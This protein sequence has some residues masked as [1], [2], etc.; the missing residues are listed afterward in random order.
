MKRLSFIAPA[1]L[2]GLSSASIAAA[3]PVGA[4]EEPRPSGSESAEAEGSGSA[5]IGAEIG[6]EGDP[7]AA[8]GGDSRTDDPGATGK[9][10]PKN[11]RKDQKWIHRW[12]PEPMTGELGI[13]G[14]VFL[15]NSRLELFEPDLSLPLQG[16][17]EFNS[18]APDL[19]ARIGFYPAA[20][21]GIEA[22]G[23][24]IPVSA[25]DGAGSAMGYTV[26][27]S[28]VAQLG[29]WSITPF[30]LAGG[31]IIGVNSDRAVV[32]QDL[33]PAIHFG[34]GLKFY[35]TRYFMMRIDVRDVLSHQQGVDETLKANNLEAL[36]GLTLVLG[37]KNTPPT[38]EPP[39]A[40]PAPP[41]ERLDSDGDGFFDDEDACV[42]LPGI[43]PDGC[44]EGDRDGDGFLDGSDLCPDEAGI[45]PGG[46][47]IRDRDGDGINDPD[48]ICVDDPETVNEFQDSDGCPDE[49]PDDVKN[50][51]GVVEGIYFDTNKATIKPGSEKILDK[52]LRVLTEYPHLRVQISGYT[53]SRGAPEHN[54][55]LS[56][57]RAEAVKQWLV[58]H[59]VGADRLTTAGYGSENP[60]ESNDTTAGRAKNRRIEF[61]L[62][63]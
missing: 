3:A 36:L 16:F 56:E 52:A 58:D 42:D 37:R 6:S 31:G 44:P 1:L 57:A 54:K 30:I 22:E 40:P 8:S 34:G 41:P 33:D 4:N 21:F 25:A 5:T 48:D 24:V 47:P 26:R 20:Y 28:L 27:G 15:P 11:K 19:G 43:A 63:P 51:S 10:V 9:R 55:S 13:Y 46:C 23:G 29:K 53:D 2:F 50:F 12:A 7:S 49:L 39:P 61:K 60:I 18:P 32:G 59:G 35:F 62:E 14:G 17:R 38:Q 45:E